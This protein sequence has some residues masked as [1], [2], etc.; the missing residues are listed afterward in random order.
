MSEAFDHRYLTVAEATERYRVSQ[1][2]LYRLMAEGRLTRHKRAADRRVYL[3][4]DE[5]DQLFKPR[6]ES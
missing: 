3:R 2:S 4:V 5:L 1:A 6:P